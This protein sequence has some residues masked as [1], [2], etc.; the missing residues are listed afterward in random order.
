[1]MHTA[2]HLLGPICV[3]EPQT[4][5]STVPILQDSKSLYGGYGG[6]GHGASSSEAVSKQREEKFFEL[7]GEQIL[8][9]QRV[10]EERLAV[11]E[12]LR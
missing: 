4:L 9:M 1:M 8:T 10:I 7:L 6:A 3:F 11:L 12:P 2:P 5:S